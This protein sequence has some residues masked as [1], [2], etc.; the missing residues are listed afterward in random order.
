[1]Q[2]LSNVP[3]NVVISVTLA[4]LIHTAQE[5][6]RI[7]NIGVVIIRCFLISIYFYGQ[8]NTIK[9]NNRNQETYNNIKY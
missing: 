5:D 8:Y 7:G 2:S 6:E 4:D 3:S 1:M 9:V